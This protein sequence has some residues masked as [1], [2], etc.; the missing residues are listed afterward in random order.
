MASAAR[1][2]ARGRRSLA[3]SEA[4]SAWP[5]AG[6]DED[7]AVVRRLRLRDGLSEG[8]SDFARYDGVP[9][10]GIPPLR[11]D[12]INRADGITFDEAILERISGSD[13]GSP[14]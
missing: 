10:M 13:Q 8:R 7:L 4:S 5:H 1:D 6:L 2:S 9:Q 12:I 11:I 14:K 3:A